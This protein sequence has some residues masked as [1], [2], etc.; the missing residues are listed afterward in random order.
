MTDSRRELVLALQR[1]A[2][3]TLVGEQSRL[4]ARARTERLDLVADK[5]D[6]DGFRALME[7]EVSPADRARLLS[8]MLDLP[9]SSM[10][11][12]SPKDAVQAMLAMAA[13]DAGVDATADDSP[14]AF[15][16]V[17]PMSLLTMLACA[18]YMCDRGD[19]EE[20][21]DVVVDEVS[22]E[23][24]TL[25]HWLIA[26]VW[27][28]N[29]CPNTVRTSVA[30]GVYNPV[31]GFESNVFDE[32][33]IDLDESLELMEQMIDDDL[34]PLFDRDEF[35]DARKRFVA[36]QDRVREEATA[37]RDEHARAAKAAEKLDI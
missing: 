29:N 18:N 32:V 22:G 14:Y 28:G 37:A 16:E 33:G 27:Y 35:R 19:W 4:P 6:E 5:I 15:G 20:V 9:S 8:G 12:A 21:L 34:M 26:A 25:R 11:A 7:A 17:S 3:Q 2:L 30:D 13:D 24:R 23:D 31:Y 36:A 10:L 1:T